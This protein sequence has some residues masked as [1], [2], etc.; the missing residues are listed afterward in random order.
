MSSGKS[1]LTLIHAFSL[2]IKACIRPVR[3]DAA[4]FLLGALEDAPAACFRSWSL[5]HNE[6]WLTSIYQTGAGLWNRFFFWA[7]GCLSSSSLHG[8]LGWLL[9]GHPVPLGPG[10][11]WCVCSRCLWTCPVKNTES[12]WRHFRKNLRWPYLPHT[13]IMLWS[14]S[15]AIFNVFEG[16]GGS[17]E[18][19]SIFQQM[20]DL[21]YNRSAI[22]YS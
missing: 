12:L 15:F 7:W 13:F 21:P 10:F 11:C 6:K 20:G 14:F 22:H 3:R 19:T 5:E 16:N 17:L 1:R 9:T 2:A 8:L 4:S 18:R